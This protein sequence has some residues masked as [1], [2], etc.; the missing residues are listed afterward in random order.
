MARLPNSPS[1]VKPARGGRKRSS[2]RSGVR[3]SEP[4][5]KRVAC[6]AG[7][8]GGQSAEGLQAPGSG[9]TPGPTV[10]SGWEKVRTETGLRSGR[11]FTGMGG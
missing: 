11:A 4:A 2:Q 3:E 6:Q 5:S 7:G 8:I 1:A 9:E 10:Q